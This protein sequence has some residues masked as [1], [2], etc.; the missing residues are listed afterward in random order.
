METKARSVDRV[1]RYGGE[2][3]AI[4]MLEGDSEVARRLADVV[5]AEIEA[6]AVP[7]VEDLGLPLT[8]SEG[9]ADFPRNAS[10]AAELIAVADKALYAAKEGG[11]N[12]VATFRDIPT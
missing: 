1:M 4:L 11:L 12:R 8:I 5:R 6:D 10:G 3:F 9:V 7:A 2:E